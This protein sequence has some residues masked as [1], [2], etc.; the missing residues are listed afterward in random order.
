MTAMAPEDTKPTG[1]LAKDERRESLLDVAAEIVACESLE[2]VSMEAVAKR[3]G[4][5][6]PLVYKHFASRNELLGAVYHRE[7]ALLHRSMAREV[8]AATSLEDMFRRLVRAAFQATVERGAMFARLR[9]AGAWSRD[10]ARSQR[11]RDAATA[12]AFTR[13][14]ADEL[15]LDSREARV[16][17]RLLLGLI[18][19]AVGQF[20]VEPTKP[21]AALLEASYMTIVTATLAALVEKDATG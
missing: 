16:A 18:D 3:A 5:S 20:R 14:A 17:I 12:R 19:Q 2:A 4:V 11:T 9:T 10:V 7:A 13:R 21:R 1:R 8:G 15:G 6:R